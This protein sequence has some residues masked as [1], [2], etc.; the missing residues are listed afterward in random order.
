MRELSSVLLNITL[1]SIDENVTIIQNVRKKTKPQS[2]FEY[3]QCISGRSWT[4]ANI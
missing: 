2:F 1:K 3:V 4:P